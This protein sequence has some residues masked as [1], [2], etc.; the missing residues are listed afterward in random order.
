VCSLQQQGWGS[1][2]LG[3]LNRA[4]VISSLDWVGVPGIIVG[5]QVSGTAG[6]A[7]NSDV[8]F[9]AH[10]VRI[11]DTTTFGGLTFQNNQ[12][13]RIDLQT[14]HLVPEPTTTALLALGLLGAGYAR[15]RRARL[16]LGG[17]S[18]S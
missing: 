18:T 2:I 11:M 17:G 10:E 1:N 5:I 9:S 14:A 13:L 7:D 15:R 6:G 8:T 4:L 12:F 3:Q 16:A